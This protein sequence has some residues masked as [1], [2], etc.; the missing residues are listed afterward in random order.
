MYLKMKKTHY[1]FILL[2]SFFM[3]GNISI[4]YADIGNISGTSHT[5]QVCENTDC[6]VTATSAVNFGKFS[7]NSDY[8]VTVKN[9][10]LTGYIWGESFGWVVL[11]CVNTTSGCNDQNN[12]FKVANNGSGNL[13]GY[14]WGE[15]TGWVN[16]GPFA[17]NTTTPVYI[18]G[19]GEFN[20]YAWTQNFG[21]IKFDCSQADYCVKT[22]WKKPVPLISSCLAGFTM[23]NGSCVKITNPIYPINPIYPVYPIN[24]ITPITPIN[25]IKPID[26]TKPID[27][28]PEITNPLENK[29]TD[30]DIS[31]PYFSNERLNKFYEYTVDQ[32]SK[33]SHYTLEKVSWFRQLIN[34]ILQ[35][36]LIATAMILISGVGLVLGLSISVVPAIMMT[37]LSLAERTMIPTRIWNIFIAPFRRGKKDEYGNS[38]DDHNVNHLFGPAHFVP[39]PLDILFKVI[40]I[41]GYVASFVLLFMDINTHN[42]AI[43]LAYCGLFILNITVF[44]EK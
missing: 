2:L 39:F 25:P 18:N 9:T 29:N 5:A 16:F 36:A 15:S 10:E 1:K 30:P 24:P 6:T 44:R 21:W 12:R 33:F 23:Q 19:S 40:F 42:V 34:K 43:F 31:R 14:A 26:P 4:A 37:P 22:T 32:T 17:N 11:N 41:F 20:G 35:N 8:N 13:S 28:V 38:I 27:F 7:T 3:L